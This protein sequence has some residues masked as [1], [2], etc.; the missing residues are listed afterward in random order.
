MIWTLT[1]NPS[2][3]YNIQLENFSEG[4]V[5]RSQKE[6]ITAGGKGINVSVVLKN[7]GINSTALGFTGGWTGVKIESM[8]SKKGVD[9][10]FVYLSQGDSR[11]NVKIKSQTETE[12]NANGPV[13]DAAHVEFLFMKLN[14]LCHG[15]TLVLAGS[16]PSCLGFDFYTRI[17]KFLSDKKIDFVVDATG[18]LLLETLQ[19]KPFL[20]KPNNHELGESFGVKIETQDQALE[21][22]KKLA[23][24]GARNV[25]VSLAGD[26][27]VLLA[28]DGS[29]YKCAAPKGTVVNSVGAGDSMVAGFIAGWNEKHEYEHA[30]K[31]GISCGSASAFSE[32]LA[33]F[34]S[35]MGIFKN[36][37]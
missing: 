16:I 15:D 26:G 27:A 30:L 11:I 22:A 19:Y 35:A 25:L 33:T 36:L 34:E 5:N 1:V 17:M 12:I 13:I 32:G 24:K 21:Y 18:N 14:S 2:L 28:E 7:L 8:L 4:M 37:S 6:S 29:A 20:I 9:T 10:D 3:D 31:M 23:E